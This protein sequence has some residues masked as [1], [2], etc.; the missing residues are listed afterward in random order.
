MTITP[1]M[2]LTD[3]IEVYCLSLDVSPGARVVGSSVALAIDIPTESVQDKYG[4]LVYRCIRCPEQAPEEIGV[5]MVSANERAD[6]PHC[7]CNTIRISGYGNP[8]HASC[9]DGTT[10]HLQLTRDAAD[11]WAE[12]KADM[13]LL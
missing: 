10:K 13:G 11:C 6:G 8:D 4:R 7:D 1:A 2:T 3:M 5:G 12:D 9:P